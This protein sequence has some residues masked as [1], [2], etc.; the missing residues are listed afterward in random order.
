MRHILSSILVT[1]LL[2]LLAGSIVYCV[3]AV[4]G[5]ARYRASR[6]PRL[7]VF[8]PVS[9]LRPLHG[10]A[11]NTEV[12]LRSLFEQQ[13]A[14]FE[15]LL[16]VHE[17]SDAAAAI[18]RKVMDEY[19]DVRSRLIV[20]GV[21]PFPNAKVWSLRALIA[22]AR[23]E[24]VV[25]SDSDIRLPLRGFQK[26][27]SELEQK[28][29]GLVTCPYR[30][31]AG[32]RFWARLEALGLNTEFLAGML[33]ARLLNGMDFA[34]GCTIATR[35]SDLASI[36]GLEHL[37]RYLAEDFMMGNLMRKAGRKVILSRCVIEHYIGDD[38][39]VKN[40]R[41][42]VRWARSTRRSR[43]WGYLGELF[44]KTTAIALALWVVEPAAWGVALIGLVFR[45]AAEW[46]AGIW[47]LNDPLVAKYWWLLPFE[48][49]AG[50]VTWVAGF[51]GKTI[52]WRGRRL[53][54]GRD[55]S[56]EEPSS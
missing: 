15:V 48:G 7:K 29:V 4:I 9:V 32:P 19:P 27:I 16:S 37:Q 11:D 20:V 54:V 8:P 43:R 5:A 53:V 30:A 47:V 14:D 38:G 25:M 41:H 24:I 2:V 31:A 6:A 33:T 12:N 21:S 45:W 13:Y 36:G 18:A 34:I 44:T 17:D 49:M 26:I 22:E 28:G 35:K 55:G 10:A 46:A 23:H 42:R 56:F 40:W 1:P 50:F 39:M 3:L 51:F 52:E